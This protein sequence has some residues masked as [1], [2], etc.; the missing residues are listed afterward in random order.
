MHYF[1]QSSS[2]QGVKARYH[3]L[4]KVYHPD[5]GGS[6]LL[7]QQINQAYQMALSRLSRFKYSLRDLES[8]DTVYVNGTEC[9]VLLVTEKQFVARAI[10]RTKQAWFD[11]D[12][13]KGVHEPQYR[14]RVN[15]F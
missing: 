5:V 13:G 4:A 6:D 12:S 14:A 3:Q 1:E 15:L 11:R 10:G 8:G 2:L 9:R 7:M